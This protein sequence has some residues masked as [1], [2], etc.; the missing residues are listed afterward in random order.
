MVVGSV[1]G[2]QF[3]PSML[4]NENVNLILNEVGASFV[5]VEN[6]LT[7]IFLPFQSF[8]GFLGHLDAKGCFLNTT[9]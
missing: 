2:F 3:S 1:C 9:S 4:V 7:I 8:M 5:L 6:L